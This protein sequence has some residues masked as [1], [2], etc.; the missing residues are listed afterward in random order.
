[1]SVFVC[2]CTVGTYKYTHIIII[3]IVCSE[4]AEKA[5]LIVQNKTTSK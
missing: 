2:C 1:M 4:F 3:V 5:E